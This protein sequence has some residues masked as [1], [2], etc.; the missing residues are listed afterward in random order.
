MKTNSLGRRLEDH[1]IKIIHRIV[2]R[3]HTNGKAEIIDWTNLI[4]Q[5][6]ILKK[7]NVTG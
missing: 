5:K 3:H 6:S 4:E 2:A 7:G 1:K